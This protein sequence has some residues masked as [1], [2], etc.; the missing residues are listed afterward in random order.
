MR[1]SQIYNTS[2]T[3][4]P[5]HYMVLK[6]DENFIIFTGTGANGKSLISDALMKPA[7]GEYYKTMSAK[8]LHLYHIRFTYFFAII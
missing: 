2:K 7:L 3:F 1:V 4:S 6:R 8:P 5:V